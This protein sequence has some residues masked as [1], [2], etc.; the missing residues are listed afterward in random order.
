MLLSITIVIDR[1]V[2]ITCF[3]HGQSGPLRMASFLSFQMVGHGSVAIKFVVF[4][5]M[6]SVASGAIARGGYKLNFL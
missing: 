5:S 1:A 3:V 6:S 2:L 4:I